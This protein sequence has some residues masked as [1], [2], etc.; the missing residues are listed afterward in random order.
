MTAPKTPAIPPPPDFWAA[1]QN[2][3]H[4]A[5]LAADRRLPVSADHLAGL[6]AECAIKAI[7]LACL[8][9][10]LNPKNKP[11]HPA[12][13]QPPQQQPQ[14]G[15]KA[16]QQ[17]WSEY[18]H[19]H[20]P[21]LWAQLAEVVKLSAGRQVGPM[22]Q[23][24]LLQNPFHSWHVAARY[25]NGTSISTADLQRHLKAA[26]DLIAAFEYARQTGNGTLR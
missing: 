15:Q 22:F 2:H 18:E 6:A 21:D 11:F 3:Y 14:A 7:L 25:C 10:Q 16:K 23:Q 8:G 9:S 12:L 19:G 20:L 13:K 26:Y 17:H 24:M 1:G 5:K 4:A